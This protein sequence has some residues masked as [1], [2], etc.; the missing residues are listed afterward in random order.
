MG[1]FRKNRK[2]SPA[3]SY[4][5][6]F[7]SARERQRKLL[8]HRWQWILLGVFLVVAA[9]GGYL[10]YYYY[11]LQGD[12]QRDFGETLEP[13]ENREDP[14]NV[15]LVGSDSRSGLTEKEQFD[16]GA[17]DLEG[18]GERADTL[19]VAHIDPETS[20]VTMVQFPRDLWVPVDGEDGKI[21]SALMGGPKELVKTVEDLSGLDINHYVQINIAGFRDL[22]DAIGGVEVCI[23][24]PIP[25]DDNTGLE[26]TD[27]EV[28]MV[29]FDGDDALRFVRSRAFASGDF[30]R[31][32]NQQKF[33]AAALD[34]IL[35]GSTL[36]Q[37]GRVNALADVARRNVVIDQHTTLKGL[38]EIGQKLRAF[39][40]QTYEAYT[41]PNLG[42]DVEGDAS[43]VR[44][45]FD[46]MEVMFRAIAN[47][48]SPA[49]ADG[50]PDVAPKTVRVAVYNG[51]FI[52]GAASAVADALQAA[53]AGPEGPVQIAEVA[54][55]DRLNYT[56]TFIRYLPEAENLA[57]L[58]SAAMPNAKMVEGKTKPGVDVAVIVGEKGSETQEIVQI[59]PIPLPKPEAPPK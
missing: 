10:A 35:S 11:S 16:L 55:A 38:A 50:V 53:T 25:F 54:N 3:T 9:V 46:T 57:E 56:K 49:E 43:I 8:R 37:P 32:Q 39:D 31:I 5:D 30:E 24:K 18:Q 48:E 58:I 34:K 47:N 29:E 20:K 42:V 4:A 40:P 45:D 41:A 13:R 36:L 12:I 15:V 59:N 6:V 1:L 7:R 22:V 26:V 14:F 28:G 44:A 2:T 52:D 33:I 19:I 17:G 21:N 27:E 23:P 51:S